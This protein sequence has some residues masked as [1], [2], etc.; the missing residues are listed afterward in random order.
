[1]PGNGNRNSPAKKDHTAGWQE[2]FEADLAEQLAR[3]GT[4]FGYDDDGRYVAATKDGSREVVPGTK[5]EVDV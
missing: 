5:G 1:M 4:M 2:R 3:G